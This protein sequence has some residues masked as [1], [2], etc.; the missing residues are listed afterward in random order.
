MNDSVYKITG[1][2]DL[3]Q[4]LAG[5][6]F[7]GLAYPWEA[8]PKIKDFLLELAAGLPRDFERIAENV[9]VGKGTVIEASAV[10]KGPAV[11]GYD[12][13]IRHAAYLRENVIIGNEVTV[14]NSTEVKN[15]V[16]FNGAQVP[17]FNY[18]GDSILGYKA[19][20]GAGVILSNVKSLKD[21]VKVQKPGGGYL[22]TGLKKFGA[23][24]GDYVEIGCNAVLNPGTV[25][26]KGSIIYP[27][28]SVRGT[29][30]PHSIL[31]NDGR[32]T[33]KR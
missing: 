32:L 33:A 20:L 24:I 29:V 7:A 2:L 11:I 28:T 13:Q 6:L 4:T 10:I 23:V 14:G 5:A 15:T 25:V 27:L 12:S 3:D 31:K 30:P 19:H 26:G 21:S 22:D 17:H 9:W 8:L 16:L 18:A 1:L